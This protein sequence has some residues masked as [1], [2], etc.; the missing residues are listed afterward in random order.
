MNINLN[1]IKKKIN[2]TNLPDKKERLLCSFSGGPDSVFMI[3]F[4]IMQGYK[5]IEL[6][7]FNHK[8]RSQKKINKEIEY[9]K[10]FSTIKQLK[11]TIKTLPIHPFKLKNKVSIEEAG[12][13]LR[14]IYL[15]HIAKLRSINK[16]LMAHHFDDQIESIL[17]RYEKGSNFKKFPLQPVSKLSKNISIIRPLLA[18]QKKDI[19]AYLKLH[20]QSFSIDETNKNTLFKRNKIRHEWIPLLNG[21]N[22]KIVDILY[23]TQHILEHYH[24]GLQL[25]KLK[26]SIYQKE[27]HIDIDT[28]EK[29]I[30]EALYNTILEYYSNQITKHPI[31]K[32]INQKI[33]ITSKHIYSILDLIYNH[34]VG[35]HIMLPKNIVCYRSKNAILLMDENHFKRDIKFKGIITQHKTELVLNQH[36]TNMFYSILKAVPKNIESTDESAFFNIKN[37]QNIAITIRHINKH[38]SFQPLGTKKKRNILNYLKKQQCDTYTRKQVPIVLINDV[39][40]WVVGYTIS[41]PF[42]LSQNNSTIIRINIKKIMKNCSNK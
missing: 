14:R 10:R 23:K 42:K 1:T 3:E 20:K 40:A 27:Y 13:L 4:L 36:K 16:I 19:L 39:I 5:N 41:E 21:I 37:S 18:F 24:Q 26:T 31:K 33:H 17:M 25:T 11:L 35:H 15:N 7:Y 30:A 28:S 12:R 6:I 2:L 34:K 29:N 22:P 32:I 38:D 9:I 8:M